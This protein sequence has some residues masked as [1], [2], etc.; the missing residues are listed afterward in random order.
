MVNDLNTLIGKIKESAVARC[1]ERID[2]AA[3]K[4][5]GVLNGKRP[6]DPKDFPPK[7]NPPGMTACLKREHGL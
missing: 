6:E 1:R 2:L 5:R 4:A 3:D 7:K